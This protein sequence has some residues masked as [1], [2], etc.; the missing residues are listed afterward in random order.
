MIRVRLNIDYMVR[1]DGNRCPR[2][3]LKF[4]KPCH[5]G[6]PQDRRKKNPPTFRPGDQQPHEGCLEVAPRLLKP[7][8]VLHVASVPGQRQL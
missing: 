4:N 7:E 2:L 8:N 5:T 1:I 6:G 3:N